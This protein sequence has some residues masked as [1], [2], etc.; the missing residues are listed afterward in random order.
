MK[1]LILLT[2]TFPYDTGEDFLNTEVQY[3]SGFDRVLICPCNLKHDSK[4]TK[5]IPKGIKVVPLRRESL[6]STVYL[7][8]LMRP[9]VINEIG[10]LLQSGKLSSGRLHE[11]LYF[12]KHAQ[13]LY[14]QLTKISDIDSADQ[15]TVYSYW[16][17]DAAAAGALFAAALKKRSK[18]VLQISRAHGFDV[19]PERVKY[20]YLP[21]RDF[22][23]RS[24]DRLYPCSQ[25][26]AD[27]IIRQFPKYT[28]KIHPA[29]LGTVDY[30]TV[31]GK[32]KPEFHLVSCA[33]MVPV[34]RLHLIIQALTF[35]DFPV[36]W[37]HLGSGPLEQEIRRLAAELPKN[38]QVEFT[39]Q[40]DNASIMEFYRTHSVTA[41]V[42]VSS[43]EG[44]P[45]SVMEASS[46]G[47]P[48]IATD[49]GGTSEAVKDGV[50]GFL[51]DKDFEPCELME[52]IRLIDRMEQ[53]EYEKLCDNSRTLWEEKFN[54]QR[55][56]GRFYKEISK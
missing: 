7:R 55:N 47:I 32:K 38:V 19:H 3:I 30:G 17:F 51:L 10:K 40:I 35:A 42:N 25:N 21:M 14:S 20:S 23:L 48:I 46:F 16:F 37:T 56:F 41:L 27:T 6:G 34:K 36:Q 53:G 44:I 24:V 12:M 4:I 11:M 1:M 9:Y 45:V 28:E 15:V 54:A 33:Y 50:N 18:K 26:G 49:V 52:I 5:E 22:L 39:G 31:K 2:S 43:S 29:F 13:E 8:L